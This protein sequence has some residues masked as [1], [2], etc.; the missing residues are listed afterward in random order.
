[1]VAVGLCPA[2][3]GNTA[4]PITNRLLTSQDGEEGARRRLPLAA[5]IER[6]SMRHQRGRQRTPLSA[7]VS[8]NTPI[9]L[10]GGDV[11][12]HWRS[13][14]PPYGN[15]HSLRGGAPQPSMRPTS[16]NRA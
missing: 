10:D 6:R 11:P 12:P 7:G 9:P 1:M 3:C 4:P 2:F 13:R 5:I 14:N 8:G 16:Q 15:Y